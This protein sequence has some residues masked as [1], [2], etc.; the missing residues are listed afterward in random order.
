LQ[1]RRVGAKDGIDGE[2]EIRKCHRGQVL[3]TPK[4]PHFLV[5]LEG[6]LEIDLEAVF[7]YVHHGN[8]NTVRCGDY[9]F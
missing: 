6:G 2:R 5:A 3:A 7:R 8:Y 9:I 4:V 1:L